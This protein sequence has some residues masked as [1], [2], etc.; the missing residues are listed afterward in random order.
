MALSENTSL[1]IEMLRKAFGDSNLPLEDKPCVVL[2]PLVWENFKE[3]FNLTN[4]QMGKYFI[5][6]TYIEP[7][8]ENK[9]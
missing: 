7:L 3:L 8:I 5:K 2:H 1:T 6:S 9:E 4:E